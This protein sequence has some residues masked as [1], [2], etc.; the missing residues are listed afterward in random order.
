MMAMNLE[1]NILGLTI[2]CRTDA[3]V[4]GLLLE[5]IPSGRIY[6]VLQIDQNAPSSVLLMWLTEPSFMISAELAAS[7]KHKRG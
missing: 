7:R 2:T 6:T 4:Q 3:N 5:I 1:S